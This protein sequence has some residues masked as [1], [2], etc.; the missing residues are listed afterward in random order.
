MSIASYAVKKKVTVVMVTLGI[1]LVGMISFSRLPQELFPPITFPQVTVVTDY[2]NAAPEEI[3]TLITKPIEEAVGSVNGLRRLESV[4]REGRSTIIVSFD[5]GQDINF[6]A[7]AVREKIDLIK[8]RL[9]KEAKDPV[10][11]KF[12]PLSRPV[13]ILSV[14]G[15]NLDPVTLKLLTEKMIKDNLEKVPG[16]AS[17]T[18]SGG[19]DREILVE[20][21]QDK[22]H[23]HHLSLLDVIDRIESSNVT[24]PAGSIKKGLYEYLIRTVGEFR[25]VKEINYVVAGVDTVEKIKREDTSFLERGDEGVRPTIDSLREEHR[26]HLLEKRLVLIRDI[27]TVKDTFAERTSYSRHNGR[28]NISVA[29]QKQAGYNTIELVDRLK[30]TLAF[31]EQDFVN[32]GLNYEII[33]DHSIYIRNSLKNL[34]NEALMGG[35]LAFLVLFFFLRSVSS[36]LLVTLSIPITILGVFFCMAL[37]G[38]TLN[39]MSLGG[40][41]L[42]VGM[43]VDTSIVVL[44]NIFRRR[45]LGEEAEEG[46]IRGTEEVMWPVVSSNMT[47]IAVFFP[48][49][50][51]VPGIPGQLFKDLSWTVIFSQII[52]I[53]VPLTLVAMLSV[54]VRV[55]KKEYKP[56]EWTRYLMGD[57]SAGDPERQQNLFLVRVLSVVAILAIITLMIFPNLEREV[58]PKLD[59][60]QFLVKVDMPVGTRLEVT[61]RV[62]RKLEQFLK[63]IPEVE[64]IAVTVGSE[65]GKEGEVKIETLRPWQALILVTLK[66]ERKRSSSKIMQELQDRI[67]EVDTEGATIDFVLQGSEFQFAEGGVKPIMIEVKG[68]DLKVMESLVTK[69][70]N[71]LS[72][73]AGVFNVQDDMSEP[74]P[75]TKLDIDKRRAA[76][77]G[78]S[79]LDISLIAKA[80]IDGVVA[81]QYR[82]KGR[83]YDIRVRLSE[84]DRKNIGNLHNLLIYSQVLDSLIPLKEVATIERGLGPSEIRHIDQERAIV[85]T[86]DIR[87]EFKQKDVLSRVQEMLAEFDEEAQKLG[88]QVKLSGKAREIKESFSLVIFAFALSILLVYMIMASQFESF[89]QPLIIMVTVPLALFGVSIALLISGTSLNV[90]SLLG[91]VILGGVVVNNG[92][93]LIEYMN[94][95]REQGRELVEAAFE[96]SKIRTRPILMSALTTIFGLI[97]LAFGLGEGAEL[98]QPLA[99]TVMGG[100]LTSTF[101]TLVVIPAIYILV[102]RLMERFMVIETSDERMEI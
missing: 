8:E 50:V 54:Y 20:I 18:V 84:K 23:A 41:A 42:A 15:T 40:L 57:L 87:K 91:M 11:L 63:T 17:A 69:I 44:E 45:Q 47:T 74:T 35:F 86:A 92:I 78:V 31:L 33:Y 2:V 43:I 71:R 61:N 27:A 73:L 6:A 25:S 56:M 102:G 10:V 100:L 65:K 82:E 19:V 7:L 72:T 101:L 68:Y 90:I 38:I 53:I 16:V 1:L 32:K 76:L 64:S 80:A 9:P 48:L 99:I 12:D 97:P 4:S 46:A 66:E 29:I 94:Q 96:A 60:G 21:D 52:A 24:Y 49:I 58:L 36:S 13:L 39:I 55:P 70:K 98:R 26:Q 51:F 85:I 37:S 81:T 93:V 83:E 30:K 95:L 28:E 5:W 75:E 67:D 34:F 89:L 3:E 77:Y 14:T 59:Q 79:A 88:F 22:L 62:S